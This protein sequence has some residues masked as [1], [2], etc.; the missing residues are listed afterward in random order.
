MKEVTDK[1]LQQ[2]TEELVRKVEEGESLVITICG[3]PVADLIP[4]RSDSQRWMPRD[5]LIALLK[6]H[7]A[8]R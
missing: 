6:T 5:E 1:E 8:D 3:R 7:S 4:Y 2:Q